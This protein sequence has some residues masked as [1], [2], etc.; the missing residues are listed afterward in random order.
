MSKRRGP[1]RT[2]RPSPTS[3]TSRVLG[4]EERIY[5]ARL[6]PVLQSP[7]RVPVVKAVL[8]EAKARGCDPFQI[9]SAA[10]ESRPVGWDPAPP[11]P[12]V[13]PSGPSSPPPS[14]PPLTAPPSIPV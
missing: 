5:L 3:N 11:Y 9:Y 1:M 6:A 8:A 7:V 4:P 12:D 14:S 10:V 13:A 2:P